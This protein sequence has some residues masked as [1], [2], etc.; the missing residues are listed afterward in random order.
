ML[1]EGS[2]GVPEAVE[3]ENRSPGAAGVGD[4]VIVGA[5]AATASWIWSASPFRVWQLF[6]YKGPESTKVWYPSLVPKVGS[7]VFF[8]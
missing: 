5:G 3:S 8:I 1:V 6:F 4:P 7:G 2:P